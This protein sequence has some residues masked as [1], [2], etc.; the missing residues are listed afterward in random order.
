MRT[1]GFLG[2]QGT[3]SEAAAI[4]LQARLPEP[5]ELEAYPDI[6]AAMQAVAEGRCDAC[7]VP[8]ENS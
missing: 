4:F 6:Y 8:V 5:T 7:L 2:P 3:H 1:M